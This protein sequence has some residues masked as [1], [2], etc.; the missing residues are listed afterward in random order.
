V[1]SPPAQGQLTLG[2]LPVVGGQE[3][4]AAQIAA[5]NLVFTPGPDESG[6]GYASFTFQVRDDG[7][8][9]NGGVDLDPTPNTLTISVMPFAL[10]R[11]DGGEDAS[12]PMM[13]A[14]PQDSY[15]SLDVDA[16]GNLA[17]GF[18]GTADAGAA[19][20]FASMG[21]APAPA[22]DLD[23]LAPLSG[24]SLSSLG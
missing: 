20:T 17:V 15:L 10:L 6:I 1:V 8:I 24:G 16:A 4:A 12:L 11:S 3:I 22:G 14:A 13:F 23:L 18:S 19:A 2:G 9:A 21:T 5:G 7:G